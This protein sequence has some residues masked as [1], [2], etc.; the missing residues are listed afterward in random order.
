MKPKHDPIAAKLGGIVREAMAIWDRM[1]A[2]GESRE[3][4]ID[5][6]AGV[7]KTSWP[8]GRS[9]PWRYLC[10]RCD[11]TGLVLHD[12]PGDATC[13][14]VK[15]HGSHAYGVPCWCEKGKAF[16]PKP[17][18]TSEDELVQVGKSKPPTRVGR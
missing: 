4:R 9:Q 17:K 15:P 8:Q 10:D 3:A 13:G 7:L 5:Y 18:A 14:R 16:R 12:C 11:D 6:L 1:R 2:N